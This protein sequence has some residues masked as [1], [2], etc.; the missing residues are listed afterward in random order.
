MKDNKIQHLDGIYINISLDKAEEDK[1]FSPEE[2]QYINVKND[3][4]KVKYKSLDC[5]IN[6][7]DN[8]T[9]D[10]KNFVFHILELVSY[11]KFN[12]QFNTILDEPKLDYTKKGIFNELNKLIGISEPLE[13]MLDNTIQN[14]KIK[15]D[16]DVL[17]FLKLR[18]DQNINEKFFIERIAQFIF[19]IIG[20]N[21]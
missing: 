18:N 17:T 5:Q 12:E 4:N 20:E 2:L 10:S 13:N 14:L 19:W 21:K 11:T 1:F 15:N 3:S 8:N 6:N 16:K 7:V 9:E